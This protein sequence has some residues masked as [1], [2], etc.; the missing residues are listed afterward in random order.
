MTKLI[1]LNNQYS[2]ERPA[3]TGLETFRGIERHE[4][5]RVFQG[6]RKERFLVLVYIMYVRLVRIMLKAFVVV[7]VLHSG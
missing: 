5:G 7:G 4:E 3:S 6:V 2:Y 1:C